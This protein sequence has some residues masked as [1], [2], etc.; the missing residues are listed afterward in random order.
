LMMKIDRSSLGLYVHIPFCIKKCAYCDFYSQTDYSV[1][2]PYLQ[3]LLTEAF[4][5]SE[6]YQGRSIDTVYIGGGTPSSLSAVQLDGLLSS[7]RRIFDI[8][9]GAE[10]T[11]E[12][13]P[14]TLDEEKLRVLQTN[15]V[16]RLSIGLQSASN[17]EL[18]RLS[19]IH[20]YEDFENTYRLARRYIDNISL[21]L[22]FGLPHQTEK[23]FRKTL[24]KAV[25]FEPNHISMYALKIEEGTPFYQMGEKLALPNE[26]EVANMYLYACD[27]LEK[28]GYQ[29]YEISNF[30]RQGCLSRHNFRY[31]NREEYIGLGPA[32]HSYIDGRRYANAK[33]LMAYIQALSKG[34]MPPLSEDDLLSSQEKIEEEIMLKLRTTEGLDLAYLNDV[35]GYAIEKTAAQKIQDY[36]K[37]GF[38]LQKGTSIAFTPRGFLVSNTIISDLLP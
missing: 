20:S 3:G 22:M 36:I 2:D 9:D 27:F 30:A 13:N 31:W 14:A 34:K 6:R 19:R 24:E 16:N 8:V 28:A 11:L 4:M 35:L 21:D 7:L 5:V 38:L 33:D 18:C 23:S 10:F 1:V 25:A 26:D 17:Q 29:Q 15:G 32:A 12:A 37:N